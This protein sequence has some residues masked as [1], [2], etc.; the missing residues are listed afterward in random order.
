MLVLALAHQIRE[1]NYTIFTQN[2]TAKSNEFLRLNL[3]LN[4]LVYCGYETNCSEHTQTRPDRRASIAE[5]AF[6]VERHSWF[7]D[8]PFFKMPSL[9]RENR[10][11]S[12]QVNPDL[13]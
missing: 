9:P 12:Y 3:I 11:F 7:S 1:D 5:H 13:F 6:F 4:N 10:K 2:I 8:I